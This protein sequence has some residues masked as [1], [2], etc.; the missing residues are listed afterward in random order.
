MLFRSAEFFS[1]FADRDLYKFDT[2]YNQYLYNGRY[3]LNANGIEI[4]GNG[5]S[6]ASYIDWIIDYNQQAG[7]NSSTALSTDLSN[8]DVRLCYRMGSFTDKQYLQIRSERSSPESQNTSLLIPDDSYSLL[9]YKNQPFERIT[10]SS[11]IFQ[12]VEGGYAVYGYSITKPY[13]EILQSKVYGTKTT[14]SSG[15]ESVTVPTQYTDQVV[16]VPYGY[17]FTNTAMVVDFLLSYGQLLQSQ[18]LTFTNQEN[19][20]TLNWNQKIGRAHV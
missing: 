17:V 16:S 10:Y 14:I 18:G 4:Y 20:Y 19:G 15:G 2:D 3:R 9:I 5:I 1:L 7:I 11:V 12:V 8:L 13:F 6:K